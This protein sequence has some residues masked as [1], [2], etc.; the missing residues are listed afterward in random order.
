MRDGI[1]LTGSTKKALVP[2]EKDESYGYRPREKQNGKWVALKEVEQT[3]ASNKGR[4]NRESRGGYKEYEE[5]D[6]GSDDDAGS[7]DTWTLEEQR[8]LSS[9]PQT[10]EH[11]HLVQH[12]QPL[13]PETEEP[14]LQAEAVVQVHSPHP[15][16]EAHRS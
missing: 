4:R 10:V 14:H 2:V 1:V 11:S 6:I 13:L 3:A 5:I 7:E 9:Q 8:S 15:H 16:L 12:L